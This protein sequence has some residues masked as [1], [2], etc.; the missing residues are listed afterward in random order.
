M[1]NAGDGLGYVNALRLG[2][3]NFDHCLRNQALASQT[4]AKEPVHKKTGTTIVGV[5]FK[6]SHRNAP[7]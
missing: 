3:F 7:F 4:K 2:G 6:V 1:E 5:I